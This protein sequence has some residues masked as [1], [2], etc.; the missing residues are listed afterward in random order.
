MTEKKTLA[1]SEIIANRVGRRSALYAVAAVAV[2]G[3]G[4][5]GCH[6]SRP[7]PCSDADTT[8]APDT[9]RCSL[10]DAWS[11]PD[12]L[13]PDSGST[14]D[15]HTSCTDSDSGANADPGGAGRHCF[16]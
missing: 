2:T 9:G 11:A 5:A 7:V 1:A 8:D 4:A 6:R 13:V 15:A 10:P 14:P 12:G 3:L 16:G